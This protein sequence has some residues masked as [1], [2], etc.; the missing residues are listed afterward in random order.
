MTKTH[1]LTLRSQAITLLQLGYS[2]RDIADKLGIDRT[3]VQ[4][5]GRAYK[6]EQRVEPK[7]R[8]GRKPSLSAEAK[9][10]AVE[11]LAGPTKYTSQ[12]AA[13]ALHQ[14]GLTSKLVHRTTLARH[15]RK[16]SKRQGKP[17]FVKRGLPGKAL[18]ETNRQQRLKFCQQQMRTSWKH[19]LF[20][21]RK[22]FLFR[23]PGTAVRS[24]QWVQKGE[25]PAAY[26]PNKPSS[27]NVYGGICKFGVTKLHPVSGTTGF[28]RAYKNKQGQRSKNIT[29]GEYKDVLLETLLPEGQ[30]LF[31]TQGISTWVLQQ[32]NDPTHK[33]GSQQAMQAWGEQRRGAVRLLKGWP[34]NSPDLSPIENF[35]GI[36]QERVDARGCKTFD[37]FK[38]AVNEEW[39]NASRTHLAS[40]MNSMGRRLSACKQANG[41]R[42]KY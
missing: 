21:D 15:A 18:K 32:D 16:E 41:A 3:T 1:P 42:T 27:Y 17:I 19:V 20:T 23:F 33:A 8:T 4:R 31:S 30:R 2:T 39:I 29:T 40:L 22:R 36:V 6:T 11:L 9:Q 13:R 5:W 14:Q 10:L 28:S 25:K 37:E 26:R 35:W 38:A 24:M 34:A 7:K 12:Q